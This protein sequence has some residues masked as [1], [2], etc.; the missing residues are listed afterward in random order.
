MEYKEGYVYQ[1]KIP[2]YGM[3]GVYDEKDEGEWVRL[4]LVDN[5]RESAIFLDPEK[6]NQAYFHYTQRLAAVFDGR[7][8]IK[9]VLLLGG[10]G[11]TYPRIFLARYPEKSMEVVEMMPFMEKIARDYFFLEDDPRLTIHISEAMRFLEEH[12]MVFDAVINDAFIADRMDK[13]LQGEI[14]VALVKQHLR[15]GGL[16]VTNL[17]TEMFGSASLP[18]KLF[19]ERLSKVFENT[20]LI[21]TREDVSVL[22]RQNF[23]LLASDADLELYAKRA[24]QLSTKNTFDE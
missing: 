5:V 17:L 11:F 16:Y 8:D 1:K 20:L 4:L 7:E 21:R 19:R 22:E 24:Y 6:R 15:P 18:G 13:G 10:A 2:H 12:D 3:L 23:L 14:G 9:S